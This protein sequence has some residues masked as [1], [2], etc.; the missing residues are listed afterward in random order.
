[1]FLSN[2]ITFCISRACRVSVNKKIINYSN[3]DVITLS[4]KAKGHLDLITGGVISAKEKAG[5]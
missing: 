4:W 1:M 3:E 2:Y 5:N